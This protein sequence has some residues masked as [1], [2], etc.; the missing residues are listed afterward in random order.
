MFSFSGLLM[1]TSKVL[2]GGVAKKDRGIN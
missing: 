2:I 1:F